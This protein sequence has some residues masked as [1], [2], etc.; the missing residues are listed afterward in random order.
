MCVSFGVF[1]LCVD[2]VEKEKRGTKRE[3]V[4]DGN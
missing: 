2:F 1:K 4:L 3:K